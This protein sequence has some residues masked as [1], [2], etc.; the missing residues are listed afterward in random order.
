MTR[1]EFERCARVYEAVHAEERRYRGE[2][3]ESR[4]MG[5]PGALPFHRGGMLYSTKFIEVLRRQEAG[6]PVADEE[7]AAP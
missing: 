6:T 5:L 3:K 7:A 1:S 2:V 4:A